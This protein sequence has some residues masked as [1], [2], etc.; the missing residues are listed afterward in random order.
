MKLFQQAKSQ[1]TRA[2]SRTRRAFMQ[3]TL[4][5][6]CAGLLGGAF[7]AHAAQVDSIHFLIPGG[8]GGGWD[9]TA[10]GTG[11][12]LKKSGLVET[13]S[14]ENLSGGGGGKAIAHLIETA[15]QQKNT[16]MVNSTPIIIR[17]LTGVFPQS[18][19]DLVPVAAT[20][21]DYGALVVRKDSPYHHWSEVVRDFKKNPAKVKFAGGST[22]GSLDHLIPAAAIK[23]EGLDPRT[24]RYV[25]YDAGGKAMAGLLSGETALLSTGLGEALEMSKAGQIRILAITAEERVSDA[26]DV[27][28]LKEMGNNTVFANWRGFFAAPGTS[29]EEAEKYAKVLG[30][31]YKTDAWET[32][33][34]RNGWVNLYKPTTEFSQFLERQEKQVGNLMRELGFLK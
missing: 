4:A 5:V 12:A 3:L 16:L 25:A 27:P 11:E 14:F 30:D 19:R 26:P 2:V 8:A 6:S 10:R 7:S 21:A 28:T 13:I 31:M 15:G 1:Q 33:R 24:L 34:S 18:F 17:S 20:V 23:E 22:R 9:G 29:S 32:V